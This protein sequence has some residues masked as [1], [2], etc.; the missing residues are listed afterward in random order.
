MQDEDLIEHERSAVDVIEKLEEL[1]TELRD[2]VTRQ[3]LVMDE[4]TRI[5]RALVQMVNEANENGY[6][7][8]TIEL[9]TD[10][11]MEIVG[12]MRLGNLLPFES[13]FVH[14]ELAGWFEQ[15]QQQVEDMIAE[16]QPKRKRKAKDILANE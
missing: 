9:E 11:E 2:H 8:I 15:M 6:K 10:T 4:L 5:G 1:K 7:T 3:L 13:D 16:R 14:D 12:S